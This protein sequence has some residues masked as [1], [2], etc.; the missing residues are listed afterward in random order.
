VLVLRHVGGFTAPEIARRLDTSAGSVRVS[1]LR[2]RR[3]LRNRLEADD[4]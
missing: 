2:A 3:T 4:D 1:L